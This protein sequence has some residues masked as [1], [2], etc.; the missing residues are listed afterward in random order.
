MG[1]PLDGDGGLVVLTSE[2]IKCLTCAHSASCSH[3]HAAG[4]AAAR[5]PPRRHHDT[6]DMQTYLT[7]V[8]HAISPDGMHLRLR[9]L[10]STRIEWPAIRASWSVHSVSWRTAAQLDKTVAQDRGGHRVPGAG[11]VDDTTALHDNHSS[12]QGGSAPGTSASCTTAGTLEVIAN[13]FR[14]ANAPTAPRGI[15]RVIAACTWSCVKQVHPALH[16]CAYRRGTWLSGTNVLGGGA[17]KPAPASARTA[18][19][20]HVGACY[21]VQ[22]LDPYD[23][24]QDGLVSMGQWL[25]TYEFLQLFLDQLFTTSITFRGYLLSS[26]RTYLRALLPDDPSYTTVQTLWSQMDAHGH[27]NTGSKKMYQ[28]FID[29]VFDFITLQVILPTQ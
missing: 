6:E 2:S 12:S 1:P 23:G 15:A 10:S 13:R 3:V 21:T 20:L 16:V 26:L 9:G 29:A 22:V 28:S 19:V 14:S 11:F 17:A 25:F 24:V 5:D 8:H 27:S 18:L 4:A 7:K